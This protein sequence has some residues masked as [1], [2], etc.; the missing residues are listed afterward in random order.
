MAVLSAGLAGEDD[1]AVRGGRAIPEADETDLQ[2]H[3]E[4]AGA[5]RPRHGHMS[6]FAKASEQ[7]H[8]TMSRQARVDTVD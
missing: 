1:G 3:V 4:L 6:L 5:R 8:V 7:Q 2:G